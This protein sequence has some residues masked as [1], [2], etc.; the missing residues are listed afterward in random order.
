MVPSYE[1][2]EPQYEFE[3]ADSVMPEWGDLDQRVQ[4]GMSHAVELLEAIGPKVG[5]PHVKSLHTRNNSSLPNCYEIRWTVRKVPWRAVFVV[6]SRNIVMLSIGSKAG[7]KNEQKFYEKLIQSA[8][9]VCVEE[10]AAKKQC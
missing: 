9:R 6:V 10:F 7:Y 1:I 2:G 5:P 3:I 8:E 4:D